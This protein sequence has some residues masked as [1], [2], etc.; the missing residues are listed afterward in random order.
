MNQFCIN[1]GEALKPGASFCTNCGQTCENRGN[2]NAYPGNSTSNINHLAG[3]DKGNMKKAGIVIGGIV[4]VVLAV[5]VYKFVIT[6]FGNPLIGKW[7][8]QSGEGSY[9]TT[10]YVKF[11]DE[12]KVQFFSGT[13]VESGTYKLIEKGNPGRVELS[14]GNQLIVY[15]YSIKDGILNL[16]TVASDQGYSENLQFKKADD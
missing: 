13:H 6:S 2:I 5:F 4:A 1:C 14:D 10:E 8:H 9:S 11:T 15:N 16:E 3:S 12:G 7:L